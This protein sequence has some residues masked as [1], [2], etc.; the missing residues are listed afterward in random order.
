MKQRFMFCPHCGNLVTYIDDKG[1]TMICCGDPMKELKAASVDAA[2]EKHVPVI[3]KEGNNVTVRIGSAEHPMKNEHYI[4][5]IVLETKNGFALK[6]L[7]PNDNPSAE[8]ALC[9]DDEAVGA[10]E[11]CN[12]HGLWQ[13]TV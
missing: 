13:E 6:K 7:T 11:Y 2:T 5:W 3:V 12:L 8:F 9:D 1:V 10:Y 4:Q